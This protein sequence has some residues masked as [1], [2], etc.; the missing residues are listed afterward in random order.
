MDAL[1][2][3]I[4]IQTAGIT[5]FPL[6]FRLLPRIPDRGYSVSK[7]LGLLLLGYLSWILSQLHILPSTQ[8][9]LAL[10]LAAM[11]AV[12]GAYAYRRRRRIAAFFKTEWRT[13]LAVELVF[14]LLF[15]GWTAY[16]AHDPGHLP[17][18]TADG[19]RLPERLGEGLLRLARR[20]MVARRSREL[21]LLR[22]LAWRE[23]S[24]NSPAR[25][26]RFAYNLALATAAA[27][28]GTAA[29]GLAYNLVR[30]RRERL[31]VAVAAGLLAALFLT[32]CSNLEGALELLHALRA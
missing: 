12:S 5:A 30:W 17:Y 32:V 23:P 18:G 16:R 4:A 8:L 14:L 19:L 29:F 27:L 11:A 31:R 9:T 15:V 10:L 21:L 28:A 6:L 13:V 26:P 22:P 7:P 20:P 3:F 25:P 2:W 24:R 1:I